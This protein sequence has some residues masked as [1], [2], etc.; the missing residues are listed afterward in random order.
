MSVIECQLLFPVDLMRFRGVCVCVCVCV[1]SSS[2]PVH[3][4]AGGTL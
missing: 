1:E 4:F 2:V 3:L